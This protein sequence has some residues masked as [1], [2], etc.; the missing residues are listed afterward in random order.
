MPIA[1]GANFGFGITFFLIPEKLKL[2]WFLITMVHTNIGLSI[3]NVSCVYKIISISWPLLSKNVG[4]PHSYP[5]WR[6]HITSCNFFIFY[7]SNMSYWHC[8]ISPIG[9]GEMSVFT[10]TTKKKK[11]K[12]VILFFTLNSYTSFILVNVKYFN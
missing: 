11:E 12:I 9:W 8:H 2:I 3:C 1:I 4:I 10:I 6:C 5:T 7:F